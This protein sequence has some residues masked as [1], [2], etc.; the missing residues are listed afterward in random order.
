MTRVRNKNTQLRKKAKAAGV[1]APSGK[2]TVG[3]LMCWLLPRMA[4]SGKQQLPLW[5]PDVFALCLY[6]LQ[7]SGAY[8]QVLS[9]WPP[10]RKLRNKESLQAWAKDVTKE[11]LNW[12]LGYTKRKPF[13]K[14]IQLRWQQIREGFPVPI[15][16]L[17]LESHLGLCQALLELCAIADEACEG[18]GSPL[19]EEWPASALREF[20]F[21]R[22]AAYKLQ[23]EERGATLCDEIDASRVRVLPKMHTPQK[24]LN[25][26]SLSLFLAIHEG[27]EVT[28]QWVQAAR[29]DEDNPTINLLLVPWPLRVVPS[30][31]LESQPVAHEMANMS[32]EDFGYFCF[33]AD[34]DEPDFAERIGL[35]LEEATQEVGPIDM[36][37]FPELALTEKQ[38]TAVT[39]RLAKSN[40]L[41]LAGV[42]R[43]STDAGHAVNEVRVYV[44]S[45]NLFSQAK[46]HRWKL[47]RP[48]IQQYG[49]G[50]SLELS[51]SWWE[52]VKLGD[53]RLFFFSILSNLTLCVLICEDLARPDPVGDLVRAVGPDLVIALLM[54]GPQIS[55]RWAARHATTLADDPGSSVLCLT[56]LG[57]SE[58]SHPAT[59]TQDRGRVVALWK[60]GNDMRQF[61]VPARK[62]VMVLSL[63]AQDAT[64]WSADGRQ[65]LDGCLSLSGVHF[66][67]MPDAPTKKATSGK[68]R[69]RRPER[70]SLPAGS[71]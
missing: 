53:R 2:V 38:F 32:E 45:L 43:P 22:M 26:R 56:S 17:H 42:G 66:M 9:D 6:V 29:A 46:H 14:L 36:V 48:Q 35:L 4:N 68:K 47:D 49:I 1:S 37:V 57:M 55:G 12:R 61:E 62:D 20:L 24:G 13:S 16:D 63:S 69:T 15:E 50:G 23:E 19:Q 39:K 64:V 52:H 27:A 60:D 41:V 31:F 33:A 58:I 21:L 5:P 30:Q 71:R 59:G 51:R 44:P 10:D 34:G 28:P 11:G 67:K 54:D 65:A 18:V 7:K 8:C 3:D 40:V 70:A 25:A